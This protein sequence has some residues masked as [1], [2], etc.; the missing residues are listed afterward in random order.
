M[1]PILARYVLHGLKLITGEAILF[2]AAN[3]NAPF[4]G[5]GVSRPLFYCF[6]APSGEL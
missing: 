6:D 4:S 3:G 1:S 2:P 5:V